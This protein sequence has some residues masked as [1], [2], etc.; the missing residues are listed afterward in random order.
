MQILISRSRLWPTTTTC[1]FYNC[2][3]CNDAF[4]GIR[5]Q[6]LKLGPPP[7]CVIISV[8]VTSHPDTSHPD[9]NR[10]SQRP[11][12]GGRRTKNAQKSPHRR[13]SSRTCTKPSGG[14]GAAGA[15]N[16]RTLTSR[17]KR[18]LGIEPSGGVYP[19]VGSRPT[20]RKQL[21]CPLLL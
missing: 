17:K 5:K 19:A 6:T 13:P 4:I 3:S 18:E 9:K 10:P 1:L 21:V 11:A 2:P 20:T 16:C 7:A 8:H 12:A 14:R 15:T